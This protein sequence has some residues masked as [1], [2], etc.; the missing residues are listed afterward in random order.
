MVLSETRRIAPAGF[1]Y[2]PDHHFVLS[3]EVACLRFRHYDPSVGRF[4]T[5]DAFG[6]IASDPQSLHKYL[7]CHSD[8][9]NR[10]D[11]TGM[12]PEF[13]VGGL[14]NAMAIGATLGAI[15]GGSAAV[16]YNIANNVEMFSG[17]GIRNLL[18]GTFGGAVAGAMIGAGIYVAAP[19]LGGAS[20]QILAKGAM[21]L[22]QKL[23]SAH[24]KTAYATLAGFSVGFVTGLFHPEIEEATGISAS[25]VSG[26][27]VFTVVNAPLVDIVSRGFLIKRGLLDTA[28]GTGA[29]GYAISILRYTKTAAFM[30]IGASIGFAAGYSIGYNIREYAV[31]QLIAN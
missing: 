17:E 8:P 19:A 15:V 2:V 4:T 12:F 5:M 6:G 31:E 11:P 7:Y 25:E 27:T 23:A 26:V 24:T 13:S 3:D 1:G 22:L 21:N 28:L 29:A 30:T 18:I 14:L 16:G 10:I 20:P 9:V